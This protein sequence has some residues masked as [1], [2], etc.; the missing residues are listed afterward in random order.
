M[1]IFVLSESPY[2]SAAMMCDRHVV[3]MI[4]ESAQM[5]STAHRVLDGQEYFD[6]TKNGRNI[7][8]WKLDD[9]REDILYKASHVNHPSNVWVREN[10]SHYSWL[11]DHFFA[12]CTEYTRRYDKVHATETKLLFV[13][14]KAPK[15]V[16]EGTFK[17]PPQCMPEQYKQ[18]ST[19]KAYQAYYIGDKNGFAKWTN[20]RVPRWWSE[21]YPGDAT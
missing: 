12:L 17:L 4:L 20:R 9:E 14:N 18:F 11:Y 15:N 8:R 21:A 3:K 2:D 5:L 1:N 19:T 13:L 6:K 16:C 10:L 7:K